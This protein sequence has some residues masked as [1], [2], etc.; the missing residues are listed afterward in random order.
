MGIAW[1]QA[2]SGLGRATNRRN[3]LHTTGDH[4]GF[5][6]GAMLA[7]ATGKPRRGLLRA[8]AASGLGPKFHGSRCA[9]ECQ[10]KPHPQMLEELCGE[11][12]VDASSVLMI[13]DTTHDML[14]ANNAGCAGLGVTYGAHA[15][16]TLLT[17]APL[18][19]VDSISELS[20]WLHTNA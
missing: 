3:P 18:H 2:N 14:M 10:S 17:A 16:D 8:F 15:R 20:T 11:F 7:V 19:C 6:P 1:T 13:G 5:L 9:D 4:T 12:G